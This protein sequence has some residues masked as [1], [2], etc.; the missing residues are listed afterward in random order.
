GRGILRQ[1]FKQPLWIVMAIVGLVLMIACANVANLLLARAV[2]RQ[3]EISVRLALG[4]GR[5][6]LMRQLLTESLLLSALGT[7]AGL[8]VAW[9]GSHV[10]LRMVDTQAVPLRLDL[11]PDR[12]VLG[13][14]AAAMVLTGLGFGLVPAWRASRLALA[15]RTKNPPG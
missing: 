15:R 4:C 14:T 1:T 9:W 12:L 11:S 3:R 6:R 10:L 8:L 2:A 7:A 5:F 13:F